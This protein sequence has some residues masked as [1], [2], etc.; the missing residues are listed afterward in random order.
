MKTTI[1]FDL[2]GTL[3]PLNETLFLKLYFQSLGETFAQF[4]YAESKWTKGIWTGTQAMVEN[5]GSMTNEERFWQAFMPFCDHPR[6]LLEA[7][8][9]AYYQNQFHRV[10]ASTGDNPLLIDFIQTLISKGYELILATNP[11]FPKIATLERMRWVGL[12]ETDFRLITTYENSVFAKPNPA[13]YQT[14]LQK[15]NKTPEECIMIGNDASEDLAA[16][17]VGIDSYLV[18]DCLNNPKQTD[19]SFIPHGSF[20]EMVDYLQTLPPVQK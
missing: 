3:L 4:G 6:E 10:R 8:F 7:H 14:I 18:T 1:L 12:K 2:D 5:D 13:Y 19:L 11:I 15:M 16:L 20:S 9:Q 17:Q